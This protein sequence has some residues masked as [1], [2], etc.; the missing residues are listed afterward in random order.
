MKY[1]QNKDIIAA[2]IDD[3]IVMLDI[4]QGKY[5]ALNPVAKDIWE[6]LANEQ[7]MDELINQL[8][9]IYDIDFETCRIDTQEHLTELIKLNIIITV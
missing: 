6:L 2:E 3:E 9:L 1:I 4:E 7:N 8:V 5:F